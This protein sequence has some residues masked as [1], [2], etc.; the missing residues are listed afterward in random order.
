[1]YNSM[2]LDTLRVG[3]ENVNL[4]WNLIE[5]LHYICHMDL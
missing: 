5:I 4:D 3:N 1:M 2:F